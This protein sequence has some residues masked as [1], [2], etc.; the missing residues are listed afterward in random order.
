VLHTERLGSLRRNED[1]VG[2]CFDEIEKTSDALWISSLLPILFLNPSWGRMN[3]GKSLR[4]FPTDTMDINIDYG[5]AGRSRRVLVVSGV[6]PDER[7]SCALCNCGSG[8]RFARALL[9]NY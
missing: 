7:L 5:R 1:C 8:G 2:C 4:R 9:V 3:S 6:E